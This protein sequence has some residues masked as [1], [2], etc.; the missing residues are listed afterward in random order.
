M[1]GMLRTTSALRLNWIA[2]AVVIA[3]LNF[4]TAAAEPAPEPTD[5]SKREAARSLAA[6]AEDL[7]EPP[8]KGATSVAS[9]DAYMISSGDSVVVKF[10]KHAD[11][12][13]EFLVRSDGTISLPLLG[14]IELAGKTVAEAETA[15]ATALSAL[16]QRRAFVSVEVSK[17]RP[18]YVV[19]WVDRAGAFPWTPDLYVLQAVSLAGGF[20][21]VPDNVAADS[22]RE[23]GQ[24]TESAEL[25][26]RSL[27]RRARLAAETE[28]KKSLDMPKQFSELVSDSKAHDILDGERRLLERNLSL[29][30]A[31]KENLKRTQTLADEEVQAL[32]QRLKAV[33]SGI[34]IKSE[35]A[36]NL[37]NLLSKGNTTTR[38]VS[39]I[40]SEVARLE[41]EQGQLLADL[42]Q[43]KQRLNSA[44]FD[45]DK[46]DGELL[47]DLERAIADTDRDIAKFATE[48][49]TSKTVLK[50]YG[51]HGCPRGTGSGEPAVSF[52][53]VRRLP[54]KIET[55]DVDDKAPVKP[56]DTIRVRQL[57][58]TCAR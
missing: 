44:K 29:R 55:I 20:P 47:Q 7:P 23:A 19:G 24:L 46:S 43:A 32:T 53:I 21:R 16:T 22:D 5:E 38:N 42:A 54:D 6:P 51:V 12:S 15:L 30:E 3:G 49:T 57:N 11:I 33:K 48:M 4:A 56:G 50:R 28:R 31:Q 39:D 45:L 13:G 36:A 9:S 35:M 10:F 37:R 2:L 25:L 34:E 26:A 14:S 58:E 8:E 52:Q 18:I 17:Y 40:E 1:N 27:A 41:S